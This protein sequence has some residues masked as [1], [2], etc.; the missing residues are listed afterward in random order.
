[1]EI[2]KELY[3]WNKWFHETDVFG[4]LK[5]KRK[6]K[7]MKRVK[8]AC[9]TQTLHFML[10]EDFGHEYAV[11]LVEEEVAKYK[12]QL[13]KSGTKYRILSETRQDDDSIIIEI[14]KQYNTS[15]VGT[16]LD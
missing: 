10:K 1:M 5:Q 2:S 3:F 8:A 4:L 14:K 16:Y 13:D 11:K 9:I 7:E 12:R 15:P 6:V